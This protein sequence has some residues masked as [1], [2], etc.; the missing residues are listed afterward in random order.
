MEVDSRERIALALHGGRPDRV[1]T[2]AHYSYEYIMHS[3]RGDPREFVLASGQRRIQLVERMF[4]H[5]DVDGYFVYPGVGE[6]ASEKYSIEKLDEF[7]VVTDRDSGARHGLLPDGQRTQAD[8][9][10]IP[11]GLSVG[12][13]QE[14]ETW[15]D[16]DDRLPAP[17]CA[18]DIRASGYFEPLRHMRRRFP[19]RHFSFGPGS[20]M[21]PA[22]EACGGFVKALTTLAD[23]RELFAEV[24]KR[25]AEAKCAYLEPGKEAGADSVWLTSMYTGAEII[26]PEDYRDLVF[27][28]EYAFCRAAREHGL[29]VLDWFLGDLMPILDTVMELPIDSLLLEQGRGRYVIDPVEIRRRIGPEFCLHGFAHELDLV[30]F[31]RENLARETR[32]QIEGAGS[33]GAL[34][35]GTSIVP[36]NARPEAVEFYLSEAIQTSSRKP[37]P[38]V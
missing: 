15:H 29:F 20:L 6:S 3:L 35:A 37:L 22:M 21:G 5:H 30:E 10:P 32:R 27:P 17:P 25:V 33:T 14:I 26:S 38:R 13:G 16:L 9:T 8:G 34:I 36:A 12:S 19:E 2:L 4:L 31:R 11:S 28:A 18:S 24:L 1:P 7:W 23:D